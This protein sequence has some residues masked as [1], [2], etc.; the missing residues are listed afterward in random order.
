M[1]RSN[2]GINELDSLDLHNV[3]SSLY[4]I[5]VIK[6]RRM[7]GAGQVAHKGERRGVY[8]IFSGYIRGRGHL[9]KLIVELRIILNVT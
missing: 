3:Y 4:N 6:S 9:E 8:G 7:S 1:E 2:R 5:Q